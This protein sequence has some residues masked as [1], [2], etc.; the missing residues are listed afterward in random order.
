MGI[1]DNINGLNKFLN[2][3]RIVDRR[4]LYDYR[5]SKR[6]STFAASGVGGGSLVYTNVTEEPDKEVVD[7]WD[8]Q[9]I[10]GINYNNLSKYFEMARGFISV[11]KDS[12]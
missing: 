9:L 4:G 5:I 6:V 3:I 7:R 11:D 2:T 8:T 1:A 12:N 10:L